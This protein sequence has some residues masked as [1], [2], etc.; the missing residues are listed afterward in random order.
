M[1]IKVYNS[2]SFNLERIVEVK[3]CE[4]GFFSKKVQSWESLR[5]LSVLC[6]SRLF[7]FFRC[8]EPFCLKSISNNAGE[9]VFV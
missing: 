1:K 4:L 9:A 5:R 6:N 2:Q 7:F 3:M 8:Q